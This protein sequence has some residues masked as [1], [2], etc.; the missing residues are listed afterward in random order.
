MKSIRTISAI[1]LLSFSS[2]CANVFTCELHG[3]TGF[4]GFSRFHPMGAQH[5]ASPSY[6]RTLSLTHPKNTEVVVG[7]ESAIRISYRIPLSY[8]N[9][10]ITFSGSDDIKFADSPTLSLNNFFGVYK[11]KYSASKPGNHQIAIQVHAETNNKPVI[12]EQKVDVL[13][14]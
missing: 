6:Q 10:K 9:V 8:R 14:S 7:E 3:A 1:S 2:V 4:G 5:N 11:L 12:Q 13:S